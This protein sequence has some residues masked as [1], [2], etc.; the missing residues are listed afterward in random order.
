MHSQPYPVGAWHLQI[1]YLLN[2][3]STQNKVD[4]HLHNELVLSSQ[5]QRSNRESVS[6]RASESDTRAISSQTKVLGSV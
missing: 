2:D 5:L 4:M 3:A 6:L 1:N